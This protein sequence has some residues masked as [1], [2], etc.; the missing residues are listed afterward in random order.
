M[1]TNCKYV[2]MKDGDFEQMYLFPAKVVHK[3][4]ANRMDGKP[5]SAGFVGLT[6][7]ELAV[8]GK[9]ESLRLKSRTEDNILLMELLDL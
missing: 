9:S 3:T 7:G 8:R 1:Y 6:G 2:V 4:V 5:I